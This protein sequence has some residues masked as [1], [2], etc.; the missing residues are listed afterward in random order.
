MAQHF[1][2]SE[3]GQ[4]SGGS[5][6]SAV[7]TLTVNGGRHRLWPDDTSHDHCVGVCGQFPSLQA[8]VPCD[9]DKELQQDLSASSYL[10]LQGSRLSTSTAQSWFSPGAQSGRLKKT[11]VTGTL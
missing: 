11:Q 7:S 3:G 8:G 4:A 1:W 5:V 10:L 9:D 2:K 6:S